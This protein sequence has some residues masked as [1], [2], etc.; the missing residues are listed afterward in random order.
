MQATWA[1]L[2]GQ[3]MQRPTSSA[4]T[5]SSQMQMLHSGMLNSICLFSNYEKHALCPCRVEVVSDMFK[6]KSP[7]QCHRTVYA[8]LDEELKNGVH[9]LSLKAKAA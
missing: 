4:E 6:G 1:I 7:L 2:L 8:L 9:A 5:G 3:Q